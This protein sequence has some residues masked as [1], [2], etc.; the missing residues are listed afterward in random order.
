MKLIGIEEHFLTPEVRDAWNAMDL[1]AIDPGAAFHS[2]EVERLLLDLA[3]ERLALMDETGLDVQVLSLTTPALH[4][5]G[6]D[7]VAA[8]RRTNDAVA[9]AVARHPTRLEGVSGDGGYCD[10]SD[11][12]GRAAAGWGIVDGPGAAA[13]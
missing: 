6:Q 9:A 11:I 7:A 13:G 10:G 4:D 3:E 12:I 2:G 5:F 8:A 1:G